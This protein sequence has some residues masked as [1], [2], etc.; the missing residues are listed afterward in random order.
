MGKRAEKFVLPRLNDP[1]STVR[2]NARAVL[3]AYRT[4]NTV[5]LERT[6]TDLESTDNRV[7]DLA[8]RSL[9]GRKPEKDIQDRV[10]RALE[11]LL[12]DFNARVKKTAMKALLQ[13]YTPETVN[14]AIE[15]LKDKDLR[16]DAVT[17]LGKLKNDRSILP[18][19]QHLNS[20]EHDRIAEILIAFGPKSEPFARVQLRHA[21]PTVR[22]KACQILGAV[23]T[24]SSLGFLRATA[25]TDAFNADAAK[26]AIDKIIERDKKKAEMEKAKDKDKD[27]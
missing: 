9:V 27:K 6:V 18:L 3:A 14:P 1:D 25:R 8:L 12:K 21:N 11:G 23:G 17:I 13:W 26:E 20:P 7:R 10:A 2:L 16:P 22:L 15:A 5:L 24:K 4:S 19:A